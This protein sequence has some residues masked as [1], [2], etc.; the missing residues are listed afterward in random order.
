MKVFITGGLGLIGSRLTKILTDNKCEV[1]VYD[2]QRHFARAGDIVSSLVLRMPLIE[3]A[4]FEVGDVC[5][6]NFLSESMRNYQPDVVV[7]L[8]A[9][10]VF[11]PRAPYD[12][13]LFKINLEGSKNVFEEAAYCSSVKRVI[14]ASSSMAYGNFLQ[15]P[16]PESAILNPIDRYGVTKAASEL[17]LKQ[18]MGEVKKEWIIIR[19]TSVYGET[20]CNN[21]V[22]QRFVEAGLRGDDEIYATEGEALDFTYVEDAVQG[23]YLAIGTM[24]C[25]EIY[26]I[27]AGQSRSVFEAADIVASY[28][29]HLKVLSQD[30]APDGK[31]PIRGTMDISK[32]REKL[33]YDPKYSLEK[34]IDSYINFYLA[35]K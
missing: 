18:T 32:A 17:L 13:E 21:R 16:Q 19:P 35:N 23:F 24:N 10:P 27:S 2:A 20:D 22:I 26:N 5:D 34:G 12:Q 8:A 11:N 33:G 28:F 9:I 4:H 25:N 6:R 31:R 14:F 7:H 15:N 30:K 3:G 1:L 29:P